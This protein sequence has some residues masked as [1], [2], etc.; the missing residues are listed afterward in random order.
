MV[1]SKKIILLAYV[2]TRFADEHN[3]N[4]KLMHL[5]NYETVVLLEPI[6]SKSDLNLRVPSTKLHIHIPAGY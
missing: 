3:T 2:G 6:Q 4:T 1:L 5:H